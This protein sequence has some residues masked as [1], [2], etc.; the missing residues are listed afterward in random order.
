M[1]YHATTPIDPR[2][3]E[4]MLPYLDHLFAN[5]A[6]ATHQLG[7]KVNQAV[8]EA[9][10]T[11]ASLIDASPEEIYF[12]SGATESVNTAIKGLYERE[13]KR[14]SAIHM[15]T[16]VTEHKAVLESFK[17]LESRGVRVTYLPVDSFGQISP[18]RLIREIC[19]ETVL[20]SIMS[21]NNEIG[22]FQPLDQISKIARKNNVF[23]HVDAS[24]SIGKLPFSV[25]ENHIDLLSFT[26]HK[27]YGPKG[28][29]AL[30]VRNKDPHVSIEPLIHGGEQEKGLRGGTLNVAG[31]IGFSKACELAK[32]QLV[33]EIKSVQEKRDRLWAYIQK[34]IPDTKLNG[35]PSQRLSGNLNVS[36]LHIEAQGI[37]LALGDQVALSSSSACSSANVA[38]SH[39]LKALGL[40]KEY[41]YGSIRFGL[42]RFTTDDEINRVGSLVV[43]EVLKQREKSPFFK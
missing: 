24:Q 39:V 6:S 12:T 21:A 15:I 36:F 11:I 5:A 2:V 4:A 34:H 42:G 9:R 14:R 10:K 32:E 3:R 22:S 13:S 20:I 17:Y 18:E 41:L 7:M 19:D 37:L 27:M 1:D 16:Q 30:Y 38:P 23:L 26:A 28:I 33:T 29:G 40:P 31:I 25:E 35:H 8:F 43:A